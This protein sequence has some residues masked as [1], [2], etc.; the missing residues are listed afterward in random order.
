MAAADALDALREPAF[1][2]GRRCWPCTILN[3]M[4]LWV[5]VTVA[6]IAGR[7][8]VAAGLA[9]AGLAAIWLRGYLVPFTPRVAPQLVAVLPG[10][11]FDHDREPGSLADAVTVDDGPVRDL[12]AEVAIEG[13]RL[14]SGVG[15]AWEAAAARARGLEL[16]ALAARID[17]RLPVEAHA[18]TR[19]GSD[20]VVLESGGDGGQILCPYPVAVADLA[21]LEAFNGIRSGEPS[22]AGV[23]D[24]TPIAAVDPFRGLLERCPL[25]GSPLAVSESVCCGAA[26]P[27]T[28][29]GGRAL[30]CEACPA[31][32]SVYDS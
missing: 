25:C 10:D 1:T 3:A 32:L 30:V 14:D 18:E 8:V 15:D 7:P 17:D 29:A 26:P 9:V 27:G 6:A 23:A 13:G 5:C 22:E 21:A 31:R 2:G 28:A 20:Y 4:I 16:P 24:E 11:P 19:W 12:L